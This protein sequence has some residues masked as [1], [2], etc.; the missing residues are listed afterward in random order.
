[1][2]LLAGGASFFGREFVR[3]PIR[4]RGATAHA[5]DF[6]HSRRVHDGE[7]ALRTSGRYLDVLIGHFGFLPCE[8]PSTALSR[9]EFNP[10]ELQFGA[11]TAT[12]AV[13]LQLSGLVALLSY[14]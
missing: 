2:A 12:R 14:S 7:T 3:T 4:M 13:V 9:G 5:G 10:D 1:M 6:S 8:K 11:F